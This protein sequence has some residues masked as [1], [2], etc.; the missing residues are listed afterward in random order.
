MKQI[1]SK[2][3]IKYKIIILFLF[4]SIIPALVYFFN[5]PKSI[6]FK[7]NHPEIEI[8]EQFNYLNNIEKVKDGQKKE[9][10]CDTSQLDIHH[11]GDYQ[12]IYHYN[13]EQYEMTVHVVDTKKPQFDVHNLE[14][15]LGMNPQAS[16]MVENIQDDT[17]T[18]I[19]FAKKY[20]F[21]QEGKVKVKIKVIDE[22][23]NETL[24]SAIV[25]ILSKD[26]EK[27][28]ISGV[29]EKTIPLNSSFD[30]QNG[31]V[32]HDNRDPSPK[33]K[34]DASELDTSQEGN[35]T[36]I[37]KVTDRSG[38]QTVVN[39][40]ITV[41]KSAQIG[42]YEQ[43]QEKIVYLTFDDGPSA[44][45]EKILDILDKYDAKATFFVTGNNQQYNYLIK[46][47]YERGHTIGLHSYCHNYDEIYQSAT[48]YFQDLDKIGQMVKEEIGFV[49]KFIRF[50]GGSSNAVSKKYNQGIMT[51]LTKQVIQHGY[52]YYDWNCGTGDAEAN[53]VLTQKIITTATSASDNNLVM[54]AHDT[55]AKST[56]VEALPQIIEYY[57]EKGYTFKAIND[58]SYVPHHHVNN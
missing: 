42:T 19:Q 1:L 31:V 4:F 53:H 3:N 26:E 22:A 46:E 9:V 16:D 11:L 14:I 21:N 39:R 25:T 30:P 41:S 50:P 32:C 20:K 27:P 55:Q 57:K 13:D 47:A 33:L 12:I 45:T 40:I 7:N 5:H 37:Y 58:Q 8:N 36:I 48:A 24:K 43:T 28:T 18:K 35:Y 17:K 10:T 54:L 34:I 44:N 15:D 2:I 51:V 29:E 6:I 38:N 23:G 49:P 52:Q 56:T